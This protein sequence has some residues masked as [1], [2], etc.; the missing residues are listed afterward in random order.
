MIAYIDEDKERFGV[1]PIC[2]Q[3]PIAPSTYYQSKRRPPS[4]RRVRDEELKPEISRVHKANFGVYGARKVWRQL[5]R[6]GR[7]VARCTVERLMREM[8]L[9]GARRGKRRRTTIPDEQAARPA[10]LVR[11]S[12]RAIRPNALWVADLTYVRTWEGFCYVAFLVDV[13]SRMIVGWAIRTTLRAELALEALEMGIWYRDERLDGLVHHSDRGSQYLSI[14]YTER[15]AD[16]GGVSSVGSAGD[17][18]DNALAESVIGLYKTELIERE[19]PWRTIQEVELRSF[20]WIHW[21]NHRRLHSEIDYVPP[22]EFAATYYRRLDETSADD[23]SIPSAFGPTPK[24]SGAPR[25]SEDP[26]S[27]TD[28]RSK[29]SINGSELRAASAARS[30]EDRGEVG[31]NRAEVGIQAPES[32]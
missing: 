12:F 28:G 31:S 16:A 11:R 8:G 32:P 4:A 14:R 30:E 3:L 17:S 21:Y 1:E 25:R 24:A 10:D 6:E 7:R 15:L 20:E 29:P 2:A 23:G 22:A 13:Y 19:R 5:L 26:V 9:E 18:Y 27:G